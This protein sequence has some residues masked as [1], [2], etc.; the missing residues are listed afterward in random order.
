[1]H[2]INRITKRSEKACLDA[3]LSTQLL[4]FA[5]LH[6]TLDLDWIAH[7]LERIIEFWMGQIKGE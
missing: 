6:R 2:A 1:M 3:L 7:W 5:H 4:V